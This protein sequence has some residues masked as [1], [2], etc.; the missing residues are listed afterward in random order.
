[1]EQ[2]AYK[3][4]TH[5]YRLAND[6]IE[7]I[8]TADVGPRIIHFGFNGCD[9]E[10]KTFSDQMGRRGDSTWLSYGG[11]RLWHSPEDPIRTYFPDNQPVEI[12]ES[13]DGM[14]VIQA[15]EPITGLQKV[16]ELRIDKVNTTVHLCHKLI[17]K[18]LWPIETS[19]W[20]LSVM[21]PG[22]TAI[23][24]FPERGPHPVFLL[25]TSRL[26][27]WP[28]T[29]L[30]DQRW[31]FGERFIQLQQ[32]EALRNPQKIG[33]FSPDGW[34]AYANHGNLFI[35]KIV[36]KGD[37]SYP[38]MGSNL[39]VFVDGEILELETLS[40]FQHIEPGAYMEHLETWQLVKGIP[41]LKND[42]AITDF[43]LP[44]VTSME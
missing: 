42:E 23:I 21:A 15:V 30:S 22:G 2:V 7:L 36:F 39:E 20:S 19:A 27:I 6:Q 1:M 11:H 17:N 34:L 24:P 13:E 26:A 29:N 37:L 14:T 12:D 3:G 41:Q 10:F 4:W 35:K 32:S 8:V 43:V 38:D 18:T 44:I 33:I 28:Y 25:P 40:P 16:I 5:C 9:N 31:R